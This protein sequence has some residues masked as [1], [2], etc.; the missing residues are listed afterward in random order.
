MSDSR[1]YQWIFPVFFPAL[2]LAVVWLLGQVSGW[3]GLASQFRAHEAPSGVR[4]S[5]QV[6]SMGGVSE[7]NVTSLIVGPSG[8]YLSRMFLFRL[9]LPSL[10]VPWTEVAFESEG[11][12]LWIKTYALKLGGRTSITVG[13][14]AFR[15]MV[16]YLPGPHLQA[17]SGVPR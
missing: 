13:E 14:R 16:Q 15:E 2:W 8:L 12:V 5:G 17:Y 4:I 1:A 6:R 11:K 10:L 3:P 9:G 7:K